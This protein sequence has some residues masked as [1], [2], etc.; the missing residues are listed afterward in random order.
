MGLFEIPGLLILIIVIA[1][2]I[3][4]FLFLRTLQN[5]I[6]ATNPI[7]RTIEPGE[8]WLILIP[9]L[10]LILHIS[11]IYKISNTLK[12]DFEYKKMY[13]YKKSIF[14][15]SNGLTYSYFYLIQLVT[16][17]LL[18]YFY[19][20]NRYESNDFSNWLE[21]NNS[22]YKGLSFMS[23]V[24]FIHLIIYWNKMS[25]CKAILL[26]YKVENSNLHS[27]YKSDYKNSDSFFIKNNKID[28]LIKIKKLLD[29]KLI[30]QEEFESLKSEII[31][32]DDLS[33]NEI[34]EKNI[35]PI[36]TTLDLHS[37]KKECPNCKISLPIYTK[38]CNSCNYFFASEIIEDKNINNTID[39]IESSDVPDKPNHLV[40]ILAI[41][42]LIFACSWFFLHKGNKINTLPIE[43]EIVAIDSSNYNI[44]KDSLSINASNSNVLIDSTE[45]NDVIPDENIESNTSSN[46]TIGQE[47]DGGIIIFLDDTNEHGI[48]CSE[49][50]ITD[51]VNTLEI[52]KQ[53]SRE[54]SIN[55]SGNW[56]LPTESDFKLIANKSNL[57]DLKGEGFWTSD[58]DSQYG[59]MYESSSNSFSS[60]R[61]NWESS[62]LV[63]VKDF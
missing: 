58:E 59:I 61:K 22:I 6:K 8:V 44:N 10:G 25:K 36:N 15:K 3:I 27:D 23:I 14:G 30:S 21:F 18:T 57:I 51:K 43:T 52:S 60:S 54:Y 49:V 38:K 17:A 16:S 55:N 12:K 41:I 20:T 11:H 5:T 37:N 2:L 62:A 42:G 33:S 56:R 31:G 63:F 35:P 39:G 40:L 1:I 50:I 53:K 4:P 47:Y 34:K 13:E 46:F 48:I 24:A 32:D 26:A 29:E 28:E 19:M 45:N 7:N 9:F